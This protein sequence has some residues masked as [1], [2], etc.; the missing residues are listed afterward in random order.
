MI[1]NVYEESWENFYQLAKEYYK[2]K[3]NLLI[4]ERDLYKEKY[5]GYWIRNQRQ[6]Y[7]DKLLE[8]DKVQ[9]LKAIGMVC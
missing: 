9:R 3:G 5:L 8:Y 7:K 4:P 6:D 1:W 2:K